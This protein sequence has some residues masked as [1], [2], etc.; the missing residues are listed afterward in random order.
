MRASRLNLRKKRS[1]SFWQA[2]SDL[3]RVA[4]RHTVGLDDKVEGEGGV[5]DPSENSGARY[6]KLKLNGDPE[7]DAA[8]LARIGKELDNAAA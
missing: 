2:G 7:A 6:F 5:A 3:P 8:R 4:I 1:R